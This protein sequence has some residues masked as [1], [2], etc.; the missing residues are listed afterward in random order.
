[1]TYT[2]GKLENAVYQ[3]YSRINALTASGEALY[4][5]KSVLVGSRP[6]E[7][8]NASYPMIILDIGDGFDQKA[9][10]TAYDASEKETTLPLEIHLIVEKLISAATNSFAANTLFDSAGN[11]A[12]AWLQKIMDAFVY[13]A[14]D[15]YN[16][17][18]GISLNK[19]PDLTIRTWA[20]HEKHIEIILET[21]LLIR[22]VHGDASGVTT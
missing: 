10:N 22:H 21:D 3:I 1:M 4:G 20:D 19:L 2:L 7:L 8:G 11:G 15:A 12:L 16:P 17:T 6:L 18:M 9:M 14:S 5:I 13:D